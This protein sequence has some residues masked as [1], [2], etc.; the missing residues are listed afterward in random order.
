MIAH[1]PTLARVAL[2]LSL[3]LALP[4]L[5][6]CGTGLA[7][8]SYQGQALLS[9]GGNV[10]LLDDFFESKRLQK[11][12]IRVALF[13]FTSPQVGLTPKEAEAITEDLAFIDEQEVVTQGS[14]PARY[15]LSI[16]H[17]PGPDLLGNIGPNQDE[18][19]L[20]L[21]LLYAD[22]NSDGIWNRSQEPLVG[23]SAEH[24]ILYAPTTIRNEMWGGDPLQEGFHIMGVA[25]CAE[26]DAFLPF[27]PVS[28]ES[29]QITLALGEEASLI[30]P[31]IDCDGIYEDFDED[32]D[33]DDD[34]DDDHEE[35][36]EDDDRPSTP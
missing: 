23:G 18:L 31:D 21:L 3:S 2:L 10:V 29:D 1:K 36:E 17:P 5:A 26:E 16:Y 9:L 22:Y 4:C 32:D 27:F 28:G 30:V 7:D 8:G 19:G 25:N 35:G 24:I 15:E 34:D 14:L 13:W 12:P 33:D 20:A 11:A 6:S